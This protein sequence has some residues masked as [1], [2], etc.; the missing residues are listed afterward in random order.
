MPLRGSPVESSAPALTRLSST[1]AVTCCQSTR[2]QK[3]QMER[4][5][6]PSPRACTMARTALS[7]TFLTA[8]RPKRILPSRTAK[9]RSEALTSGGRTSM[10][11]SAH[12]CA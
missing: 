5:S 12:S 9:S 8:D 1:R 4:N 7:P 11:M 3:S 10:P 2:S 6:P